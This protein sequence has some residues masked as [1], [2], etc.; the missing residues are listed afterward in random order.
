MTRLSAANLP[1]G[2]ALPGYDRA[3][4]GVGIVHFGL[5]AFTRAH[6]AW[7]TDRAMALAGGDWMTV[8]VSLR[9]PEV[10]AQLNPQ[11]GLYVLAERSGAGTALQVIGSV[12]EVLLATA[13]Q[14][15]VVASL[16]APGTHVVTFTVTE[17][18]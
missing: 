13:E 16:A 11:D 8:G 6:Q 1:Q 10:G 5:G 18:G 2:V 12:R 3:A 15:Q 7:Y 14:A 17:K 9:S 4:K